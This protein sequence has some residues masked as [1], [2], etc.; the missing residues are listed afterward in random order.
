MCTI[1][2]DIIDKS[3]YSFPS[4]FETPALLCNRLP[5]LFILAHES[6]ADV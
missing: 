4:E 5:R 1:Y 2:V 6:I 3:K